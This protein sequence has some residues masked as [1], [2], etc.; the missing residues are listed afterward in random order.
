MVAMVLL[1]SSAE[2]GG[3][4]NSAAL[5]TPVHRRSADLVFVRN[6][7]IQPV[8]AVR[9]FRY[10]R[11]IFTR[12]GGRLAHSVRALRRHV[13]VT[14]TVTLGLGNFPRSG[15]V[16]GYPTTFLEQSILVRARPGLLSVIVGRQV[17]VR[18]GL[19]H[20]PG[21]NVRLPRVWRPRCS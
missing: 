17:S 10:G 21:V 18:A 5:I 4:G 14:Y 16:G 19:L 8:L 3:T 12:S 1:G 20:A 13:G 2:A 7:G 11:N 15:F 6:A 9:V